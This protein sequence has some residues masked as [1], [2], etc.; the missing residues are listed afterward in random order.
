[1]SEF[2]VIQS[3]PSDLALS[4]VSG[5][6]ALLGSL[7]YDNS[8]IDYVADT[9]KQEDFADPLLGRI[10]GVILREGALRNAV[11]AITL[12][13]FFSAD[14][15]FAQ[16]DGAKLLLEASIGVSA[17]MHP[18][19]FAEQTSA[20][21]KRRLLVSGFRDVL[22]RASDLDVSVEELVSDADTA[23]TRAVEEREVAQFRD[24]A[25]CVD[26][27]ISSFTR[28][29]TGVTCGIV[30]SL[31]DL[32]GTLRPA[33]LIILAGRPGMGKT[34][35]AISYM[36]GAAQRGH[37]VLFASLEMSFED[38]SGR[39]VADHCFEPGGG[40]PYGALVEHRTSADHRRA[41]CRARD[42][43]AA[44]PFKII[45]KRCHTLSQLRRAIRRRRR[46]LEAQ[47]K[48]LELVLIDYLQLLKPDKEMKSEFDAVSEVSRSLKTMA[49]E[50]GV[51][52][53][54]LSQLSRAVES[55]TDKRPQLSDLRSSGQIEQ[56]ADAVMFL[57][58]S[59]YYLRKEKPADEDGPDALAEWERKL[60]RV[61]NRLEFIC[62]KRRHGP[63][64]DALGY[65]FSEY[66][67]VRGGDFDYGYRGFAR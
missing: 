45:D 55:R 35:V 65:F 39:L 49:K 23:L 67:A 62:A 4:N 28:P 3:S 16:R 54:A 7:L 42:D 12:A 57:Y 22:I 40:V 21:A 53:I 56:D 63:E 26:E 6:L 17:A 34:A 61:Q 64:G 38:L 41:I 43:I 8:R 18:K 27:V 9:L 46:E 37:G 5:E 44:L 10:F 2:R 48:K 60:A 24:G 33:H 31:D 11:N 58:R 19:G 29:I 66:Q 51:A 15:E 25:N 52:I 59:E 14:E 1:M 47:G 36:R 32:L 13:P 50:E 30:S 20:L